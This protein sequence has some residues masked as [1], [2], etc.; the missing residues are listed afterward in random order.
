MKLLKKTLFLLLIIS[1]S[2][3]SLSEKKDSNFYNT[4][5]F[6]NSK[7]DSLSIDNVINLKEN[8]A[9][10]IPFENKIF[11]DLKG[12]ESSWLH[13][14]LPPQKE[15]TYFII[16]NPFL[17]F[18][19]LYLKEKTE[20]IP[21]K[22]YTLLDD[23]K[24]NWKHRIPTW[25]IEQNNKTIDVYLQIKDNRERTTLK[26]LLLNEY[27]YGL[28]NQIDYAVIALQIGV[29]TVL[30]LI[31][32]FLFKAK[33]KRAIF[34]YGL[35]VLFCLIEFILYKGLDL[36]F[37]FGYSAVFQLSKRIIFQSLG[38]MCL[39][40]F[41]ANFYPFDKK[42]QFVKKGF[43]YIG[44]ACAAISL[45]FLIQYILNEVYI[46]KVY[47]YT[48]MRFFAVTVLFFHGFLIL[49]K[50]LPLYLGIAF[51][52]PISGF[53]I[54]YVFGAPKQDISLLNSFFVDN[55]YPFMVTIE[56]TMIL[57]Y[58]VNKLIKSEFIALN[59]KNE[60]LKLRTNFQENILNFQ[61]KERNNL[62]SNV[63]D[64]FGGYLEALK[65]RLLNIDQNS[66]EKIQEILD[67]FYNDYRYLLNSLYTPKID[68]SN[69]EK[70]LI[71]FSENLNQ[72]INE[73]IVC[74]FE[75]HKTN[76][77]Q[78]KCIHLYRI[79]LELTTNAIKHAKASEI[80][81]ILKQDKE[82]IIKLEVAD[83][84]VGFKNQKEKKNSS[85]GLKNVSERV[86]LMNGEIQINSKKNIGS[87]ITIII[88][89]K[90]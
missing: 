87:S 15:D 23:K 7:N 6:L 70:N 47:L 31:V 55:I 66:P 57:Y 45:I 35:Y 28:F 68:A 19:K 13:F 65:I 46:S 1:F 18:G 40:F 33:N 43:L 37:D 79:I 49:K 29:L 75:L 76:L 67:A 17:E 32:I 41:F 59:F 85:Y 62:V 69:F 90:D 50:A 4:V 14:K 8:G 20:V 5:N 88:S 80:V 84:G 2:S 12:K 86:Y 30:L 10:N 21:L 64:T 58:I 11:Y 26:F 78:E 77:S 81:I 36:Q 24:L 16:W 82:N 73:K 9:F 89:D 3:C 22:T 48:I 51:L 54:F 44:Y 83:N 60:N 38:F 56:M 74:V 25:K 42:S 61:H 34:W 53:F 71:E 39:M 27:K 72:L 63:H 52:L